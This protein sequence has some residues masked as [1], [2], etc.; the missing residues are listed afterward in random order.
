M[1]GLD[2]KPT[3]SLFFAPSV[4]V[5]LLRRLADFDLVVLLLAL[6]VES[7]APLSPN[8]GYVFDLIVV[9]DD[10][11]GVADWSMD[12][13]AA[14]RRGGGFDGDGFWLRLRLRSP[15]FPRGNGVAAIV[16]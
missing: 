10:N 13:P 3:V 5:F 1:G 8:G 16:A 9:V 11:G 15:G 7:S 6:F 4:F 2:P 14:R 12:G